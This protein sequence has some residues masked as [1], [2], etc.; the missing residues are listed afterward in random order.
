[1]AGRVPSA[2]RTAALPS[3]PVI[4]IATWGELVRLQN[5]VPLP[6]APQLVSIGTSGLLL[7]TKPQARLSNAY[8]LLTMWTAP[9]SPA[10][11]GAPPS[12]NPFPSPAV[13]LPDRTLPFRN[14]QQLSMVTTSSDAK[15][16]QPSSALF[17][18]RQ[19]RNTLPGPMR[20]LAAKPSAFS[21]LV[22]WSRFSYESQLRTRLFAAFASLV[23]S[24]DVAVIWR[25]V[26]EQ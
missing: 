12:L 5:A 14:A 16:S 19:P 9:P 10:L 22:S 11:V 18:A 25:P 4:V 23:A 13:L 8:E 24:D 7:R 21:P 26:S 20:S 2:L 15:K 17:Q 3:A 6:L 1:M